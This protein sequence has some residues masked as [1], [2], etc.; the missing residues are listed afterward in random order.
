MSRFRLTGPRGIVGRFAAI[1]DGDSGAVAALLAIVTAGGVLLGMGAFV[2]DVGRLYAERE[3]LQ[4]GADAA[5]WAVAEHCAVSPDDCRDRP[6]DLLEIAEEYA[7]ANAADG[8]ASVAVV[9]GA[10]RDG[11]IGVGVDGPIDGCPAPATNRTVCLGE[12]PA[13]DSGFYV[14]VHTRT[15]ASDGGTLLPS[16]FAGALTG[17]EGA[18]VGACA[19]AA[20]G[21]PL[22]TSGVAVTFSECEWNQMTASGTQLLLPWTTPLPADQ[23]VVYLK[24]SVDAVCTGGPGGWDD[25]PGGFG[26]L[27]ESGPC[28]ASV[29]LGETYPGNPGNQPSQACRDALAKL[30][31]DRTIVPVPIYDTVTGTGANTVYHAVGFAG[32][33]LTGYHLSGASVDSWLTPADPSPC[34]GSERCLYGYFVRGLL[35]VTGVPVGD[36]DFGLSIVNL[37]G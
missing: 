22:N 33:V 5:A 2:V 4:T 28:E 27:D 19:R 11:P 31:T 24:D 36:P 37:V 14:E 32:F 35:P 23:D 3:Q 6:E 16:T 15:E 25:A 20:W 21:S 17:T 8:A 26:W 1:R 13:P 7:A 18:V 29:E 10:G 9:C 30:V 34:G 12:R